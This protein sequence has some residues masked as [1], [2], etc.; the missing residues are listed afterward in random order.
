MAKA[1]QGLGQVW[2]SNQDEAKTLRKQGRQG[3]SIRIGN[4][5]PLG[6]TPR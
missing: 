6:I 2:R 4:L 3:L 5:Q 1:H